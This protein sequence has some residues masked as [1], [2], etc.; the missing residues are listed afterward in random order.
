MNEHNHKEEL[1]E[2][3]KKETE[4]YF[5]KHG[6]NREYPFLLVVGKSSD[7]EWLIDTNMTKNQQIH[8]LNDLDKNIKIQ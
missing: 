4:N 6:L 1:I 3:L 5:A 8:L 7:T 2:L